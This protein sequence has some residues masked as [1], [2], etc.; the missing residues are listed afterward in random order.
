MNEFAKALISTSPADELKNKMNL[1]GQFV[2]EWDFEWAWF[3]DG[4]GVDAAKVK[5]E[6]LFSWILDG[7]AVQDVWICPSREERL[8]NSYSYTEYGTS[9]RFYNPENDEWDI[10]YGNIHSVTN[11]KV[12][13]K[14]EN[15]ITLEARHI[16][17]H[18]MRWVFSEITENS[19]LWQN[20]RSDDGGATWRVQ[21]EMRVKR[22][23]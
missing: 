18:G 12:I 22:R 4:N 5:G 10:T 23:K 20:T 2:G 15:T 8:K 11:L 19:F 9:I 21:G 13:Q 6:W 16:P 7:T 17:D 14:S 1:F 3:G